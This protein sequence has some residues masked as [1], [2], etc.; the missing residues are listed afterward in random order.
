LASWILAVPRLVGDHGKCEKA[1]L[2]VVTS[3]AAATA[4]AAPVVA[5]VLPPDG[6]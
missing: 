5:V 4:E 1:K 2:A 6:D 3:M